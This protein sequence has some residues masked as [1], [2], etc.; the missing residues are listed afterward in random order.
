M[1]L[2]GPARHHREVGE[3][4]NLTFGEVIEKRV[5]LHECIELIIIWSL[6]AYTLAKCVSWKLLFSGDLPYL[7][8]NHGREDCGVLGLRPEYLHL[9]HLREG[10]DLSLSEREASS[11]E[12]TR[13][14]NLGK[15][16]LANLGWVLQDLREK[17]VG[18]VDIHRNAPHG[19]IH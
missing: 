7:G 17:R 12:E 10:D 19:R 9:L 16:F 18:L 3:I 14:I 8:R 15:S 2:K 1:N 5:L 6:L 4:V 11:L 13:P